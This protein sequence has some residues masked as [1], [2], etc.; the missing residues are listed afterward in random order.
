MHTWGLLDCH[1]NTNG[2]GV[3]DADLGGPEVVLI[4][5][6]LGCWRLVLLTIVG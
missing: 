2:Q 3:W 4:G 1:K 5:W 6:L